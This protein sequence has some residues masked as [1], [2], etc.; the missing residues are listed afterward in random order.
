MTQWKD[1]G[2]GKKIM[3]AIGIM[4]AALAFVSI[5]VVRGIS[6]I[7]RDGLEVLGREQ[8]ARRT[9]PA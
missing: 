9:A 3:I 2:I 6:D 1:I 8:A 7:V 5:I 4:I